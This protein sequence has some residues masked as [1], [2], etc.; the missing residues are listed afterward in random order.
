VRQR[1]RSVAACGS[2]PFVLLLLVVAGSVAAAPPAETRSGFELALSGSTSLLEGKAARYR[3]VAYRV[4]GLAKLQPLPGAWIRARYGSDVGKKGTWWQARADRRGFFT[5]DVPMPT[6]REG[7]PR[8]E[9]RVGDGKRS[10]QFEFALSFVKAWL[11][12]LR[13]DRRLYQPGEPVH[14]WARLRDRRSLR[15]IAGRRIR[16]TVTGV[17][18]ASRSLVTAAS[19]VAS[20]RVAIPAQ[21]AEGSCTVTAW[22][23]KREVRR[24]FRVGTRTYERLFAKVS[25][26]PKTAR[27]HQAITVRVK[28][29]TASGALVRG[30]KINVKV[31]TAEA[32]A[33]TDAEGVA[34]LA[35]HAPAYMT[36]AT[37]TISMRARISHPAHGS[38]LAYGT[39]GL[40]VPHTLEVE[41]LPPNGGLV[42]EIDSSLYIRLKD[43][44][45]KPPPAGTQVEVRGAAIVRGRQAGVTDKHG[46]VRVRARLPRGAATRGQNNKATTTVV[47][48]IKGGAVV[49][50]DRGR[51]A[52]KTKGQQGPGIVPRTA[53]VSVPV[54]RHAEVV[55]SVSKPVVA[56]GET[57]QIGLARRASASRLPVIV[58]LLAG[59]ELLAARLAPPNAKQV[60]F[61]APRDRLGVIRVRARPLLQRGTV[62]GA[63]GVDAL[64]V[65]PKRPS[66]P[67]LKAD[68]TLYRVK[69]TARLT[70]RTALG[71]ARS[72]AA[73]LVRDLAA[74]GGERPFSLRF[75]SRAFDRAILD[76]KTN[77]AE[78]LLR[79]ALAAYVYE[80]A[81]PR[82]AP[83]LLDALGLPHT[84]AYGLGRSNARG[85]LRDPFPLAGELL[86]RGIGLVMRTIERALASALDR[87][88]LASVSALRGRR[89]G[90]KARLLEQLYNRRRAPKTLGDGAL[91]LAMIQASDKS[92]S[93]DNVA[94][95]VARLRLVR[96]M[97]ALAKYLDPGDGATV[98]QRMAAREPYER[99]LPRMVER[100]LIKAT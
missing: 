41:A 76:P 10:R 14:V 13:T 50:A 63:G 38:A 58:E 56:S 33:E 70:L 78:T 2:V 62:E 49:S 81:K 31:D 67:S 98:Q 86:R 40:A 53:A 8:L 74:H 80:D 51:R 11:L 68:K 60:T 21:A 39:L 48:Q 79:A 45:G 25:V 32:R 9:I 24:T 94:R 89:R 97:V 75:L 37:G 73:V 23:G 7:T 72:W 28:V 57:L 1:S 36:H 65:R 18:T 27:P 59:Q 99:W 69:S 95:R 54:L 19:G 17:A 77:A 34:T 16:L 88:K 84:T 15:P 44:A 30:A 6:T 64:I 61:A 91:T 92:F 20:T 82:P 46:I 96:L 85:V 42:P 26:S 47:V 83:P 90:F 87:G 5:I 93:Y 55:P 66:F 29:T 35:M 100:G 12:D 3:G 71:A 52:A 4:L 43:G 22:I